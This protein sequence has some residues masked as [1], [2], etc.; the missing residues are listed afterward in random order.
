MRN[1]LLAVLVLAAAPGCRHQQRVPM[2]LPLVWAAGPQDLLVFPASGLELMK[3]RSVRVDSFTD[4]RDQ[5]DAVG[6]NVQQPM[7]LPVTARGDVGLFLSG[8]LADVLRASGIHPVSAGADRVVRTE[9]QRFYVIEA[10]DYQGRVAL[11]VTVDD[12]SGQP[13]WHGVVEGRSSQWGRSYSSEN[14]L[15]SLTSASLEAY[16]NLGEKPGFFEAFR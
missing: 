6:V 9:I 10:N 13:L 7:S 3:R 1:V 15:E 8:G 14:F 2:T 4:A 5:R 16:K 11:G 12:G